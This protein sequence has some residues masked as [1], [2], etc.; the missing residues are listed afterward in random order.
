MSRPE[1]AAAAA[2][3]DHFFVVVRFD[4]PIHSPS[5]TQS[6]NTHIASGYSI[7]SQLESKRWSEKEAKSIWLR[8]G[9]ERAAEPSRSATQTRQRALTHK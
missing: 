6:A 3:F 8:F 1:R 7:V 9:M 4:S 2:V 5:A